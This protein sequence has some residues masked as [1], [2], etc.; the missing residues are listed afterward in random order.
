MIIPS[1]LSSS[2]ITPPSRNHLHHH[3]HQLPTLNKSLES[4]T[5]EIRGRYFESPSLPKIIL[6]LLLLWL[7]LDFPRQ[8]RHIHDVTHLISPPALCRGGTRCFNETVGGCYNSVVSLPPDRP[9]SCSYPPPVTLD[10]ALCKFHIIFPEL[11]LLSLFLSHGVTAPLNPHI[12]GSSLPH[13]HR[14][15]ATKPKFVVV[16][17][18]LE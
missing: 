5:A 10:P 7:V 12:T 18:W 16:P 3:H 1:S 17:L 4:T 6:L 9:N 11:V 15:A 2:D 14:C 8:R 13:S